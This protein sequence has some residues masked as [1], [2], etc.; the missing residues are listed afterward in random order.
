MILPTS[1]SF[2]ANFSGSFGLASIAATASTTITVNIIHSGSTTAIGTIVFAAAGTVPTLATTGGTSQSFV[3][4]DAL[5]WV[6]P[7]SPDVTLANIAIT[8]LGS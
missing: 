8:L 1:G 2:A 7:A 5:E 3:A 4:G 6:F